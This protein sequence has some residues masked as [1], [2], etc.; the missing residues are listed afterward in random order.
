MIRFLAACLAI[1]TALVLAACSAPQVE[2]GKGPT[3]VTVFTEAGQDVAPRD[4]LFAS[5]GLGIE[6]AATRFDA[7]GLASLPSHT[8]RADFPIGSDPRRFEGPRLSDILIAT[9]AGGAGAR[10][11]A[12]DGYQVEVPAEMIA[13]HQPVFATHVDGE[14]LPLGGLGPGLLVWPRQSDD[15]LAEMNDE[16]WVW[17]VFAIEAVEF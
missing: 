10:L 3:L 16:M 14:P 2:T 13:R 4:G 17:G 6:S 7:Q 9:G 11:T 1:T 15:A 5:Y 12:A 8:M